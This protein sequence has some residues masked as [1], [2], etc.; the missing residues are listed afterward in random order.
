MLCASKDCANE[1]RHGFPLQPF[2]V[3]LQFLRSQQARYLTRS[4][5]T[6]FPASG[7]CIYHLFSP[8]RRHLFAISNTCCPPL[9]SRF[10]QITDSVQK[11]PVNFQDTSATTLLVCTIERYRYAVC[12]TIVT[13][14]AIEVI[15]TYSNT[16][17]MN[18]PRCLVENYDSCLAVVAGCIRIENHGEWPQTFFGTEVHAAR[19]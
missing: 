2:F 18:V 8:P 9:V 1:L 7:S 14:L 11:I 13:Y 19:A 4:Y 10:H 12:R 15:Y 5:Q 16:Q 17:S 3:A 6:I